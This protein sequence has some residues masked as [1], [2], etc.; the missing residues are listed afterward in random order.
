MTKLTILI[1]DINDVEKNYTKSFGFAVL[2]EKDDKKILFDTG[3]HTNP[4]LT[5]LKSYGVSPT[6]LD[7]IILSHN[8]NDHTNG[9]IGI[10]KVNDNIPIFVHKDWNVPVSF[11]GI[12]IPRKNLIVNKGA[13]ERKD[14][15]NGIYLTNSYF[16][17]DYGKIYEHACYIKTN[18]SYILLC[19]CCH[20]GLNDFLKD[21]K[22]LGISLDSKLYFIGGMHGFRFSDQQAKELSP[23]VKSII[24]CHCTENATKFREQFGDRCSLGVVGKTM[25]FP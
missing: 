6:S 8:H 15:T 12:Q 20:P 4:L 3:T 17:P 9:I 24:L 7:A 1:D 11:Q 21:R 2:I 19:G 25:I 10:L 5:N 22:Q 18:D 13:R 14:I 23:I 16:S